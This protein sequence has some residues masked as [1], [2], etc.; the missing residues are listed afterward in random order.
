MCNH[1]N[2]VRCL[3]YFPSYKS[4]L[5]HFYFENDQRSL[6]HQLLITFQVSTK[7]KKL[8]NILLWSINTFYL[9]EIRNNHAMIYSKICF[10][11]FSR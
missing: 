6:I 10:D 5:T 1:L 3:F 8:S 2:C 11:F 9:S 4:Y 7:I